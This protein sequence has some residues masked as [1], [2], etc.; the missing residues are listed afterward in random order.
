MTKATTRSSTAA[1]T[2]TEW[3]ALTWKD[4][5]RWAGAR[6]VTRG[7]TYQRGNRVRDLVVSAE[8][9]LLA[10]VQGGEEY[11][12]SIWSTRGKGGGTG[13]QSRCSC[14]VGADGCKHAVA[15]VAEF[16]Q[17]I[18]ESRSVPIA[19]ADDPRWQ[20]LDNADHDE[21]AA[22][23]AADPDDDDW[24]DDDFEDDLPVRSTRRRRRAAADK[25]SAAVN[26]GA[27]IEQHIREKSQPEL[28]DLVWQFVNRFP[29]LFQE[30][31]ERLALQ[32]GDVAQL[33]REARRELREV[34]SRP[35]Y[36]RHWGGE[37]YFPDY[38]GL[39]RR[40]ERLV[41]LGHADEVVA[42]GRE[43]VEAG[44]SQVGQSNDEG[45]TGQ[46]L[47]SC[48]PVLFDAVLRS[49]LEPAQK[50]LYWIDVLLQ[51]DCGYFDDAADIAEEGGF[52]PEVWSEVADLLSARLRGKPLPASANFSDR[53]SR[54]RMTATLV[55][56]L[57]RAGRSAELVPLMESEARLTGSYPQLVRTL[58]AEDRHAEAERWAREGIAATAEDWPGIAADLAE[59]LKELAQKHKHWKV[60]AAHAAADFFESPHLGS[61]NELLKAARKAKCERAV[62]AGAMQFLETGRLPIARLA[63]P[64]MMSRPARRG[65]TAPPP[66]A[67][68]VIP[69]DPDW[70]LPVP[71]YLLPTLRLPSEDRPRFD[72]LIE[73][74]IAE[75]RPDE[76]LRWYDRGL[77]EQSPSRHAGR[78]M[79]VGYG[80]D[81]VAEAVAESH[82]QRA[83]EIYAAGLQANLPQANQQAYSNAAMYLERMRPI[84]ERLDRADDWTQL[85]TQ[86]REQYRNRPRFMQLLD[87][88][89]G[90][91]IVEGARPRRHR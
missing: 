31:R 77:A 52:G 36:R 84:C 51:D 50:V 74:A 70:P 56:A 67:P 68:Q 27:Q 44:M 81:R 39:R 33:L 80:A 32:R 34:T 13:L 24:S 25:S 23:D 57:T 7:R 1:L 59:M 4:L 64:A 19:A 16:L 76:V 6:S 17:A 30:F 89:D 72:V 66:A 40:M 18:A 63:R 26:W 58:L 21:L 42:L 37:S 2:L 29:E 38:S 53:Y 62:R 82:P 35:G 55:D 85:L 60:V 91:T 28:A 8:G 3:A 86:I 48:L 46:E 71:D 75:K 5:E 79:A 87:R 49:K 45:E 20:R 14:P 47:A 54:E 10:S 83:L 61:L 73:I 90:R 22:D 65:K 43:L 15:V 88:L 9:R 69:G 41:E 78:P 11:V 12:T